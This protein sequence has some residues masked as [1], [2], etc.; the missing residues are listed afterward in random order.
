MAPAAA[1]AGFPPFYG[2]TPQDI[3][4]AVRTRRVAVDSDFF[5]SP[6]WDAVSAEAKALLVDGLL[7][8]D[9]AKRCAAP[10]AHC[11]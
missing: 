3:L 7:N 6:E 10:R 9:P 4:T 8:R 5:P 11:S 1:A 2:E